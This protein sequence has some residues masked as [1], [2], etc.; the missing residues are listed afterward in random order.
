MSAIASAQ[1]GNRQL[2]VAV[3]A[4]RPHRVRR[5]IADP[6]IAPAE[7]A[8]GAEAQHEHRDD[9][10]RGID[11]VA[12]DVAED[13]DPDDLVDQSADAGEEEEER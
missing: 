13:A 11:G 8:A 6:T 4:Q 10:R 12:E 9:Q 7:I 2:E 3:R 5:R 1:R